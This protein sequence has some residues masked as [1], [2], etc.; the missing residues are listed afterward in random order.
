SPVEPPPLPNKVPNPNLQHLSPMPVSAPRM[1]VHD[2][3]SKESLRVDE[4]LVDDGPP[5]PIEPEELETN[6][7]WT[8]QRIVKH[9]NEKDW[10]TARQFLE[11]QVKAVERG[12][13]ITMNGRDVAPDVRILKHLI[14]ISYSYQGNFIMA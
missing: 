7:V 3:L 6:I 8:A 1:P 12:Q 14:G 5:S 9:W 4:S 10:S 2:I 13:T 11:E